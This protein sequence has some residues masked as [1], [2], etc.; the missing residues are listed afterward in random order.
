MVTFFQELLRKLYSNS[1]SL[2]VSPIEKHGWFYFACKETIFPF[3]S[4][5]NN[6]N[7]PLAQVVDN[8]TVR[9][10]NLAQAVEGRA[11][12]RIYISGSAPKVMFFPWQHPT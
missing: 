11:G 4:G 1:F 10:E 12:I 6:I 7:K 3:L 8:S 5:N 9:E 2:H